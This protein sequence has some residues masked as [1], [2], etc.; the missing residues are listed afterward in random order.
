M[1]ASTGTWHTHNLTL[2]LT[3]SASRATVSVFVCRFGCHARKR[4]FF[5]L[6]STL[7]REKQTYGVMD[8]S[9]CTCKYR[10]S[11]IGGR[12]FVRTLKLSGT[13]FSQ[14]GSFDAHLRGLLDYR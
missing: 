5:S 6:K 10:H 9:L 3:L 14:H 12:D 11:T 13:W 8:V 2:T 1:T 4:L 7:S